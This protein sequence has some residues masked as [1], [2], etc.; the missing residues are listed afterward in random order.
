MRG[1]VEVLEGEVRDEG[2]GHGLCVC[3]EAEGVC[4]RGSRG[5]EERAGFGGVEWSGVVELGQSG[6]V[7][8]MSMSKTSTVGGVMT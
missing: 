6:M 3:F 7:S 8:S 4:G 1:V 5:E 2:G